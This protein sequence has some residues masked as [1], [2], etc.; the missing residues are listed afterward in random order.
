MNPMAKSAD[1]AGPR[2]AVV[3]L[4]I[5]GTAI[6]RR[7]LDQGFSIDVWD[8]NPDHARPLVDQG[9]TMHAGVAEAVKGA[10][11]IVTMLSTPDAVREVMIDG[12]A[13]QQLRR[14]AIWVQMGTIGVSATE[15]LARDVRSR[16]P[17]VA[18]VDAPVSGSEAPARNGQLEILAG[19]PEEVQER[20]RPLFS[21]LGQRTV[22]LGPAG[23]GSRMKLVLNV[24]LAFDIEAIAEVSSLAE[25]LGFDLDTLL[26]TVRD[27]PLVSKTGL[28]KLAKMRSR[29]FS[30]EF[31][32]EWALK[33]L[34]LVRAAGAADS[35]PVAGSIAERWRELVDQGL[36]RLD[37]SA[38]RIGLAPRVDA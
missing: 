35:A 16:R 36:G 11:V 4:G 15:Q 29:D 1:G 22:W 13:I 32:L 27:S 20:L 14:N 9:A 33:D 34:D 10:D 30:A 37:I 38:A 17:D 21:A 31:P 24:W 2:V 7:L 23:R 5:M 6:A 18:F 19:G 12:G 26:D 8:R 3:G 25:K 28:V